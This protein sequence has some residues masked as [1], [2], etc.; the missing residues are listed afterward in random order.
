M[1]AP[2]RCSDCGE[3]IRIRINPRRNPR[4]R[5]AA[6]RAPVAIAGQDLCRRCFRSLMSAQLARQR[7][8]SQPPPAPP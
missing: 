1:K 3:P 8:G 7:A 6:R 5:A 4:S 2:R